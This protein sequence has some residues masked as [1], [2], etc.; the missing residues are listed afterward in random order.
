M[1]TAPVTE[2]PGRIR[3]LFAVTAAVTEI[4]PVARHMRRIRLE[5]DAIPALRVVPGQQVR[6]QVA[7]VRDPRSWL[8]PRDLLRT[9]SVWR[10]DDGLELYVLDHDTGGPGAAWAR[11][12]RPGQQVAFR[13][14]EGSFVL[15]DDAPYHL[16]AGEETAAV[17]FGAMLA[18][19]PEHA[20]AYGVIEVDDEADR[21]PLARDLDWRYRHGRPAAASESLVE[22]VHQLELPPQP[23]VAY[24]AGEARTIQ[25]LRRHLVAERGW[26]RRAIKVKPFW[27]P[28]RRGMD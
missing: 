11:A 16:F 17:A 23:G 6:V 18:A 12:L 22:A 4:E 19:L 8:H 14:P 26:P 28:G 27:T 5:G 1:P 21:L 25:L 15:R 10:H 20:R 9:Y 2:R 7:G 24:L 3:D 13:G